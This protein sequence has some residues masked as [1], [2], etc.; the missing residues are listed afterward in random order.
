MF[1]TYEKLIRKRYSKYVS[2]PNLLK[3]L[4][5]DKANV[6]NQKHTKFMFSEETWPHEDRSGRLDGW[7]VTIFDFEC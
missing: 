6:L 5:F 1:I 3:Q 2:N 4:P 7:S